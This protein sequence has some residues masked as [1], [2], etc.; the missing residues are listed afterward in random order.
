MDASEPIAQLC[1]NTPAADLGSAAPASPLDFRPMTPIRWNLPARLGYALVWLLG[2][3]PLGQLHRL[4][5]LVGALVWILRLPQRRVALR[6]VARCYP[7]LPPEQAR[8]L[9]RS[10]LCEYGRTLAEMA[11]WWS[12]PAA[13]NLA[14]VRSVHGRAAVDAA[15]QAGRGV[16]IAAPHIGSWELLSQWLAAHLPMAVVYRPPRQAWLEPLL[17]RGRSQAACAQIRADAGGVRAM[18]RWLAAGKALG[19][20]PDQQPKAGE[21]VFAPFFGIPALSMSLLPRLARRTGAAVIYACLLRR[22]DGQGYELHFLPAPAELHA[23][24]VDTAVA[25]MNRGVEAC[26]ALAPLQYQ[27]SYRRFKRRPSKSEPKFYG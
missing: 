15:L 12:R 27:W 2:R 14:L 19:I 3:L 7:E 5:D 8:A 16:V 25:A 17:Q 26:V 20:L 10:S 22:D 23:E 21:G 9:A 1:G 11:R 6:N 18:V 24:D 13:E 4:G